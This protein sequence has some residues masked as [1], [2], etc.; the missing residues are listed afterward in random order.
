MAEEKVVF[1]FRT[2]PEIHTLINNHWPRDN[3]NS[4]NE[5]IEKAIRFYVG[6]LSAQDATEFLSR[7]LL[8]AIRGIVQDS[9]NHVRQN[10]FKQA[11]EMALTTRVIATYE[12]I[13]TLQLSRMRG[14]VVSDLKR[15]NG[16]LRLEDAVRDAAWLENLPAGED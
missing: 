10:L 4:Q 13:D 2:T 3:C 5:F 14:Q 1:S 8:P 9:E 6:Y 11:V 16:A 7:V 15:T 12:G